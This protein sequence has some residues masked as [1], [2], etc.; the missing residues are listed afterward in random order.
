MAPVLSPINIIGIVGL[1]VLVFY[2]AADM[3]PAIERHGGSLTLRY[4]RPLRWFALFTACGIPLLI[5]LILIGNPPKDPGDEWCIAGSY[6]LFGVV[7]GYLLVE[8]AGLSV[9]ITERGLE[10]RSGWRRR[11]FVPWEDVN[12]LTVPEITKH[13]VLHARGGYRFRVPMQLVPGLADFL[14]AVGA[15]CPLDGTIEKHSW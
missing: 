7:C 5:T 10:C 4:A 2:V 6:A 12:G 8:T 14:T 15:H 11:R 13:F 9:T 1:V 3:K